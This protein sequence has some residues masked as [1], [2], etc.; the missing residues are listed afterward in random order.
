VVLGDPGAGKSTL[1]R[2]MATAYLLRLNADP[3]WR[4]LPDIAA[5]PDMDW[6][7]ILVRCRDLEDPLAAVSLEQVLDHH[8]RKLGI[9][10]AEAGQLNELLLRR[11]SNGR[12]LLLFDGLTEIAQPAARA[13]F[14]RQVEQV[15]VA[16]PDAPIVVTSRIVGYREMSLR[17]FKDVTVLDLTA[18]DKDEFIRRWCAVTEPFAG[19]ESV[20]REL[21]RDIH[22]TDRIE[23]LTGNPMLLTTMVLVKKKV[24][25]LP[26]RRADLYREAVDV[27]L[28]WGSEINEPLDPYEAMPQLEYVA[29]AMCAAGV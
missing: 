18:D 25:K 14:C 27:L 13:R 17:D 4:Q 29:Y 1:L 16:Y 22:S 21:I 6:L 15:H 9:T 5:L 26:S 20:E 10:G 2:W 7:P 11:L 8:L 24:G 28:N 19:R 3:Y 12:A 23:R